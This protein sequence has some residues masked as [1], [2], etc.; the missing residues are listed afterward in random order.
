MASE[1][2]MS[3]TAVVDEQIAEQEA[4]SLCVEEKRF[5][6]AALEALDKEERVSFKRIFQI[7]SKCA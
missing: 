7:R 3:A 1:P 6:D 5:Y 4:K 2:K